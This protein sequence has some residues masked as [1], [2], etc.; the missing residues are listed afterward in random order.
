MENQV[1]MSLEEYTEIILEK[2]RLELKL[3]ALIKEAERKIEE[4]VMDSL[5]NDLDK[6]DTEK[7]L[8]EDPK[9]LLAQFG[10]STWRLT[11]IASDTLV[12]NETEIRDMTVTI[13]LEMLN[14]HLNDILEREGQ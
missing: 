12:F 7:W 13:I 3:K 14:S 4:V 5:I 1:T 2:Q 11:S 10:P 6:E 8:K 9:K